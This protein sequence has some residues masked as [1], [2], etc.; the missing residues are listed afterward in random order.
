MFIL[1]KS[2]TATSISF[3]CPLILTS[4]GTNYVTFLFLVLS[5]LKILNN[6]SISSILIFSSFTSKTL[7]FVVVFFIWFFLNT[8]V[9]HI[10]FRSTVFLQNILLYC[11]YNTFLCLFLFFS[12]WYFFAMYPYILQLKYL[13]PLSLLKLSLAILRSMGMPLSLYI[14]SVFVL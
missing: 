5:A 10:L 7:L 3:L 11:T 2:I 1:F 12:F 8:P 9:L 13:S 14:I 4:S 6:L